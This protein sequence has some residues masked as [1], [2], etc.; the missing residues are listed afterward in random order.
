MTTVE[1]IL[2]RHGTRRV[3]VVLAE[4]PDRP[5]NDGSS[6][7]VK[8][9]VSGRKVEQSGPDTSYAL[10]DGILE[11]F[12]RWADRT[13]MAERYCRIWHGAAAF[14]YVDGDRCTY[15]T[16]DPA[17]WRESVGAEPGSIDLTEWRAYLEGEVYG[18]ILEER[19]TTAR[20]DARGRPLPGTERV[21]WFELDSV[22][23]YYGY[24]FAIQS[25][26]EV[27]ES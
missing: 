20:L 6:P 25:A 12:S 16:L 9:S 8:F 7:V 10:D 19:G 26:R 27:R 22:W 2:R 13:E 5:Y 15:V 23:G 14:G 11:A 24:D 18:V 17:D 1:T 4:A 21:E 3:R